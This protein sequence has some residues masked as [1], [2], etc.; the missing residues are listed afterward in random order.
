MQ[1]RGRLTPSELEN[2]ISLFPTKFD[3]IK[4]AAK[5]SYAIVFI[6]VGIRWTIVAL[7]NVRR[8]NWPAL[9]VLWMIVGGSF[10]GALY[11]GRYLRRFLA[12]LDLTRMNRDLTEWSQV[13]PAGIRNEAESGASSFIPW[14]AFSE[15]RCGK[16]VYALKAKSGTVTI[17][18]IDGLAQQ[19]LE[20][21]R[22]IL[23]S[24]VGEP[25]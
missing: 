7:A 12:F 18:P 1:I 23:R 2:G 19:D 25:G 15:W 22:A 3:R 21:L 11:I 17:L 13:L 6:A 16:L 20:K 4:F 5:N 8:A 14:S 24:S 10:L 9:E